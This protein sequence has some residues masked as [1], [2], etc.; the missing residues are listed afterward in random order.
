MGIVEGIG[1]PSGCPTS[2]MIFRRT[3]HELQRVFAVGYMV[4]GAKNLVWSISIHFY[5]CF[6]TTWLC[7]DEG[8][9]QFHSIFAFVGCEGFPIG[10]LNEQS[11]S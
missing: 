9:Y 3:A 2:S 5:F 8:F 1:L 7:F 10:Q 6:W 4:V 11:I